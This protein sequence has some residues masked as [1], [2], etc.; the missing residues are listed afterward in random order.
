[1]HKKLFSP[2]FVE[3]LKKLLNSKG[4]SSFTSAL[5]AIILGLIFGFIVMAIASPENSL[6]GFNTVIFGGFSRHKTFK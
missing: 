4:N 2:K 5:L 3:N 1:M 6:S